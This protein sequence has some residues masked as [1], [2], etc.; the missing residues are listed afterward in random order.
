M[1]IITR[2][3]DAH[4]ARLREAMA[5]AGD[6]TYVVTFNPDRIAGPGAIDGLRRMT[7]ADARKLVA[8][9]ALIPMHGRIVNAETLEVVATEVEG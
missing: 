4:L 2:D 6:P 3:H 5:D 8:G 7:L 9:A 1:S